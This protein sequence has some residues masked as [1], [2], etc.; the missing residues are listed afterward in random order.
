MVLRSLRFRLMVSAAMSLSIALLAAGWGLSGLFESHVER[1]LDDELRAHLRQLIG[2][3]QLDENKRIKLNNELA[4]PRFSEPFSGLYWQVQD[5]EH[6]TLLRSRSLWDQM[7]PLPI[8]ELRVGEVHSHQL[9]GPD[10]Q[11]LMVEE[12]QVIVRPNS[13][14]RRLRV[15]VALDRG[16]LIKARQNFTQDMWPY[17]MLLAVFLMLASVI[18]IVIGLSPLSRVRE[19][20]AAIRTGKVARLEGEFPDEVLPLVNE[21]NELLLAADAAVQKSREWT[22]DLAHG[23]KTPLTAISSDIQRLR[24][25][26]N[27]AIA[28]ELEQLVSTMRMRLDR[29]LVRARLRSRAAGNIHRPIQ[30]SDILN[31]INRVKKAL[32]RTPKGMEVTWYMQLPESV[33]DVTID[34]SDLTELLGNL[35][36]NA[37]KWAN[38]S[39]LISLNCAEKEI[40]LCVE[41]DGIG[42]SKDVLP[43]LGQR[44]LRLDESVAGYGLGLAIVSDICEAYDID[45]EYTRSDMGGLSI[46]LTMPA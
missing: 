12:Q 27:K 28:D 22:G 21:I 33:S 3:V 43:L 40:V 29:E 32:E 42:V 1:R 14:A 26:G 11:S 44:G 37:C 17:L 4:D 34:Q 45:V 16:D 30:S 20:V 39:I 10:G 35:M 23:L 9:A 8:D 46:C 19:G 38:E 25:Q 18:Q 31:A 41:D 13:D 24:E 5:D 6:K 2:G 15:A 7:L 36:E